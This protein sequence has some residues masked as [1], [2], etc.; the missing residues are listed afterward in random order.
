[1]VDELALG[2]ILAE[3]VHDAQGRLLMPSGTELTE[4]HL[5]AFRLWGIVSVR[6]KGDAADEPMAPPVSPELLAEAENQVRDRFRHNDVSHPLMAGL[7]A[8]SA[9]QEARR[10][11]FQRQ[12]HG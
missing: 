3:N 11:A 12:G 5:R 2:M 10:L 7:F 6:I 1:M 8:A 4:R 9:L